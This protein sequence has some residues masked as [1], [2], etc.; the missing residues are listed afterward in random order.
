MD[1]FS[2][3]LTLVKPRT[4]DLISLKKSILLAKNN[5]ARVTVLAT[6]E[7]PSRYQR[8][9]NHKTTTELVNEEKLIA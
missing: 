8:W 6:K 5:H 2:N 1:S 4:S 7:K 3:I 9:L